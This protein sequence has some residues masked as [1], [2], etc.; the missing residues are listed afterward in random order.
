MFYRTLLVFIALL[1]AVLTAACSTSSL[2]GSWKNPDYRGHLGK[3]Y[4]I[5]VSRQEINRR[6][7]ED[8][9]NQ[10]LRDQ[11]VVG[12]SSYKDLPSADIGQ[13]AVAERVRANGAD[14]VLMARMIGKRTD[15]VVTPGRITGYSSGP[16]GYSPNPYYRSWGS[17]YERRYEATYEPPTVTQ[18]QVATIEA[19][20]YDVKTGE[21]IWSAQLETVVDANLQKL[22][23]DFV[24]TVVTDLKQ[25]GLF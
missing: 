1:L 14:S 15:E 21:L 24:K 2:S 9:F 23:K 22:I 16:Y 25:Q 5:G 17:Y 13:Q 7:F 18:Y 10:S 19:N 6:L 3:V 4:V 11:G 12:I 20:L 8:V